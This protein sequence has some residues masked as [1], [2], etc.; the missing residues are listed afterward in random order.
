MTSPGLWPALGATAGGG[1]GRA[2]PAPAH[3]AQGDL[4][5]PAAGRGHVT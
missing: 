4:P 5:P 3:P 2:D 1:P